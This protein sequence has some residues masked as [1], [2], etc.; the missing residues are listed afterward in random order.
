MRE[1][2]YLHIIM[3]GPV[4]QFK[5]LC[6]KLLTDPQVFICI[7]TLVSACA[8]K[9][10]YPAILTDMVKEGVLPEDVEMIRL[11]GVGELSSW[12]LALSQPHASVW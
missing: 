3:D 8:Q 5:A 11:L 2:L 10:N 12:S 7:L 6:F 1:I 4:Y 9:F